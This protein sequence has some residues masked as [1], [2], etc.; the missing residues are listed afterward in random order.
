M[1]A[2]EQPRYA[3]LLEA[4]K[5][6]REAAMWRG[7]CIRAISAMF[8]VPDP[9]VGIDEDFLRRLREARRIEAQARAKLAEAQDDLLAIAMGFQPLGGWLRFW[10]DRLDPDGD[11]GA[12]NA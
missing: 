5:A 6:C 9:P 7:N 11:D 4:A 1:S 10:C 8:D 2:P 12:G 3:R